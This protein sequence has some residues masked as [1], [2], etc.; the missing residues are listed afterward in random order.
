MYAEQA[1]R[2]AKMYIQRSM[3]N[4]D[5]DGKMSVIDFDRIAGGKPFDIDQKWFEDLLNS[6][7]QPKGAKVSDH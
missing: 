1:I 5:S 2:M 3:E 7:G 4:D 6:I